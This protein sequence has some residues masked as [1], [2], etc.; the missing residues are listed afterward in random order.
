MKR[1]IVALTFC[2]LAACE[3]A[4]ATTQMSDAMGP[5]G[6]FATDL[7]AFRAAQ[8][9]GAV[10]PDPKLQQAARRHAEDMQARGYFSHQSP[11]GPHGNTMTERM[12]ASGCQ[13]GASAEN[14]AQGQTSEAAVFAAWQ[15]STGH[16][17]NMLG[18]RY[19]EYGL[20]RSGNTWVLLFSSD[21]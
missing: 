12:A 9:R 5:T 16:R 17:R 21:C 10:V 15:N 8:G 11:G 4:P 13:P 7:N 18:A 6:N 20:G 2:A 3:T 19:T 14:I 1:S